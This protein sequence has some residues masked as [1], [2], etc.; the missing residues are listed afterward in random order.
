MSD[1]APESPSSQTSTDEDWKA[2]ASNFI[3]ARLALIKLEARDAGQ[4]AAKRGLLLGVILGCTFFVWLLAVAGMIGWIS[5]SQSWPWYAVTLIAAGL[6]LL[7]A[8]IAGLLLKKP[9]TPSFPLTRA[10]FSKDQAWLETL[11]ND[12][13]SRN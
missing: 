4:T 9:T 12:P 6:H 2:A 13:K 8:I 7:V 10:E 3:T 1:A 11:K 5:A